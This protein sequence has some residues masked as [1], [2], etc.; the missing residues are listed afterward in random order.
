MI[1]YQERCQK[2][3]SHDRKFVRVEMTS[4]VYIHVLPITGSRPAPAHSI[5]LVSV[6]CLMCMYVYIYIF[7]VLNTRPALVNIITEVSFASTNSIDVDVPFSMFN[8]MAKPRHGAWLQLGLC[9]VLQ[10]G[11]RG[12]FLNTQ[13]LYLSSRCPVHNMW[14][15]LH[16]PGHVL[17]F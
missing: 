14:K 13:D 17:P 2:R 3:Y 15:W 9:K 1:G 6:V 11:L 4:P 8:L 16:T 12:Q 5:C 10:S 7:I